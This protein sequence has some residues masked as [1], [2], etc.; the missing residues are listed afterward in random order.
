MFKV[1][2]LG[3]FLL[4]S[5]DLFILMVFGLGLELETN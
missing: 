2:G 5:K 3:V 1:L 4:Q